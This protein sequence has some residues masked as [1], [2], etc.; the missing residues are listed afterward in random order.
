MS[1]ED[2]SLQVTEIKTELKEKHGT[3]D[4]ELQY[5]LW[6]EVI[7]SR[8]HSDQQNPPKYP[9]FDAPRNNNY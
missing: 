6:E 7:V 5:R 4:N 3:K 8:M 1:S 9:M 2:K